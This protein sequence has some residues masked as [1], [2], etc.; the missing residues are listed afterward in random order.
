[1]HAAVGGDVLVEAVDE[2]GLTGRS[3]RA[4]PTKAVMDVLTS[5]RPAGDLLGMDAGVEIRRH[6]VLLR[7][8]LRV[9]GGRTFTR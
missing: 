6:T 3:L 9:S 8:G 2:R 7:E 5:L 1:V 4:G